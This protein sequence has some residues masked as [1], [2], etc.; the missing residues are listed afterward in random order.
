MFAVRPSS[1]S[2]FGLRVT[3]LLVGFVN[4]TRCTPAEESFQYR[5]ATSSSGCMQYGPA[6]GHTRQ[7]PHATSRPHET[8]RRLHTLTQIAWPGLTAAVYWLQRRSSDLTCHL[9]LFLRARP[10][11]HCLIGCQRRSRLLAW[12]RRLPFQAPCLSQSMTCQAS[13]TSKS[14]VT[15]NLYGIYTV[16]GVPTRKWFIYLSERYTGSTTLACLSHSRYTSKQA[17]YS[18][19]LVHYQHYTAYIYATSSWMI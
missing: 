4:P 16:F 18:I 1:G 13:H 3:C 19:C 11:G 14:L 5:P 12:R 2:A 8:G 7:G 6:S 9:H 17:L 10:A 15:L